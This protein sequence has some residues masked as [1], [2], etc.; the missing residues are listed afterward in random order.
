MTAGSP[1]VS[2]SPRRLSRA[3]LAVLLLA[4]AILPACT[5]RFDNV[6]EEASGDPIANKRVGQERKE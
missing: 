6:G 4:G 1:R 2:S 5:P 3:A